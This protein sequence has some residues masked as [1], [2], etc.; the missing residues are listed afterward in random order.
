MSKQVPSEVQEAAIKVC[1]S[2][3][4]YRDRL[5]GIFLSAGVPVALYDRY[6][7][8]S[9]SKFV[10][11]RQIFG[12]LDQAGEAGAA[13]QLR[14]VEELS[15][16]KKPDPE[17]SDYRAGIEAIARFGAVVSESGIL[18]SG[19]RV[20]VKERVRKQEI[21]LKACASRAQKLTE[22]RAKYQALHGGSAGTPQKRGYA[23][24]ELFGELCALY[25]IPFRR[26]YRTPTEQIDGA[27]EF[28]GF[29]YLL[30]ARWRQ[31]PPDQGDLADF[32]AKVDR[33]IDS[34]RGLFLSVANFEEEV[35]RRFPWG[36]RTNVI[37]M[38]GLD[39]ALI[40]ETWSFIDALEEK[41]RR[42][43]Q[44]G[45]IWYELARGR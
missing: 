18:L 41:I 28:R 11:A 43:E 45:E 23:L 8:P 25:E 32:K 37:L 40:F 1:G 31:R 36:G 17:A 39:L 5:R 4:L 15:L 22:L 9:R 2:A 44:E 26:S 34:V 24:E 20:A 13:I 7:D 10:I 16:L 14:I 27:F 12:D 3:L 33:K 29:T 21:R 30:E 35:V 38:S 42:A 19:G 6:D